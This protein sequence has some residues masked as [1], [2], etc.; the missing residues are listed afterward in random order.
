V[1][2]RRSDALYSLACASAAALLGAAPAA[3]GAA[4]AGEPDYEAVRVA[5][6]AVTPLPIVEEM[7]KLA[8][9]APGDFVVDLGSG[10]GRLVIAAVRRFGAKG[11]FGVDISESAVA[12][13]NGRAA[14][15]GVADRVQFA[16]RDLFT[17]DVSAA[18]VVTVYLFPAAMPRLRNKLLAELRPGTR[19]VVHDFPFPDWPADKVARFAAPEKNDAVGRSDAV[20]YLYTVPARAAP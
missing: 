14:E 17:T 19:V 7:L 4:A 20:L 9:V 2:T 12:Y 3:L 6:V 10:D 11:G 15:E 13:A 1:R 8:R 18:T 5:P 16:R